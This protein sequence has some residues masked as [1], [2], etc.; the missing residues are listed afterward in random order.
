MV[1]SSWLPAASTQDSLLE[2]TQKLE[3]FTRD[4]WR[5]EE[6]L[7]Q[8]SVNAI[9]KTSDGYM[10]LATY[11]GLARFDGQQ[12][13]I[14]DARNTKGLGSSRIYTLFA[15]HAGAL[16]VFPES[17]RREPGSGIT[18]KDG[19]FTA[20]PFVYGKNIH[21]AADGSLWS[22]GTS[23]LT[24]FHEGHITTYTQR[25]GL[26]SLSIRDVQSSS[27]GSVWIATDEGLAR[28]S[29]ERFRTYT[30]KDGLPS[31]SVG[32]ICAD[33]AGNLW[34]AS[35][36]SLVQFHAGRFNTFTN[37]D[38]T[39]AGRI[40]QIFA[41]VHGDIW[42]TA[43]RSL[44]R[45]SGDQ[46]VS[47]SIPDTPS[48]LVEDAKNGNLWVQ[49][50]DSNLDL[51]KEGRIVPYITGTPLSG[52]PIHSLFADQ[53]GSLWIGR[54][55]GGLERLKPALI[56]TYTKSDGLLENEILTVMESQEGSIWIGTNGGGVSRLSNGEV[57]TYTIEN[58]L[59]SNDVWSLAEDR[60]GALWIGTGQG[61]S[62]LESN[63]ISE[64]LLTGEWILSILQDGQGSLWVGTNHGLH[65]LAGGES[66]HYTTQN[67]L[68]NN[69]VR[70]IHEDRKNTLWLATD[71]GISRVQNGTFINYTT[72]DGLSDLFVRSIHEDS[73]GTLWFGTYGNGFNRFKDGRFTRY[74]THDGLFDHTASQILEDGLGNFWMTGNKGIYRLR[75]KDLN[76]F[77]DG[78]LR[79][80]AP[81]L[82]GTEEGL[83][84]VECNGG[85]QPA[86]WQ[87]RDGRLWFPTMG[88]VA[89]IDPKQLGKNLMPPGV[90]IEETTINGKAV[91][92]TET[93]I[94]PGAGNL[95]F[96]YAGL[97]YLAPKM[98]RY[99]YQ[100]KGF[101]QNW[102]DA[103][104]RRVAY[105]TNVPPG[106]YQFTVVAANNDG[107]WSPAGASFSFYL[108]PHFY[109]TYWF[110]GLCILLTLAVPLTFYVARVRTLKFREQQL[111]QR[112]AQRTAQ[113]QQSEQQF[114]QLFD[115]APLG[116]AMLDEQDRIVAV[117]KAFESIFQFTSDEI[118][119]RHI[120]E[121]IVPASR[122]AEAMSMSRQTADGIA[123]PR[124]TLRQ[125]KDGSLVPVELYGVPVRNQG[126]LEGMYGMYVDISERKRAEE[127]LKKAKEA[128][129]S[130]NRA[131]SA[132]LAVM[133][134]E[135]RTPMNGIIGMTDL[136]LD[137]Q[138]NREQRES[139]SLVKVS[140]EALLSVINDTLDFS[141]IEA[142]KLELESIDFDLQECLREA[143]KLLGLRAH[144]KGLELIC[145]IQSDVPQLL[146]GD[147]GRFRQILINL[148][149]NA[150]KFTAHGYVMVTIEQQSQREGVI[151][152]HVKVE[153]TGIGIPPDKQADIFQAFTQGDG[154]ITRKFGGT[155]LGLAIS[156]RL[157]EAMGGRIWVESELGRGS[158]FH[159]TITF[160]PQKAANRVVPL[161]SGRFHGLRVLLVE[162]HPI[163][164]RVL[165]G[166]LQANQME[167]T[168]V[169]SAAEALTALRQAGESG[170][171]FG[172]ILLNAHMPVMDGFE[173]A[174]H[175]K[176][177]QALL[178][179]TIM[180]LT[181]VGY[182]NDAARCRDAGI[183]IHLVKPILES[184]LLQAIR[185]AL[186]DPLN[187][188]QTSD[189]VPQRTPS[190]IRRPLRILLAE[191]N[192]FNQKLAQRVLQR[193]GH[194]VVLVGNGQE[195]V[196]AA[197]DTDF[198]LILMDL[199]MP[200]MDGLEATAEIRRKEAAIGRHVPII[201]MTAHVLKGDRERCLQCG[202]DDYLAKPLK[203][204]E[205]INIIS[206]YSSKRTSR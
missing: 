177:D 54:A 120:N 53:E 26:P 125:R 127:E 2:K 82:Y 3:H 112:V 146:L 119:L 147:P 109:E 169:A 92:P 69:F 72:K 152:L 135:I 98:V 43:D 44:I 35:G 87:A 162:N 5:I 63:K 15:D 81:S 186:C 155:G 137:T 143:M 100:L 166:L 42:L 96:H 204:S 30:T 145:D 194:E 84:D 101:D 151:T 46:F 150:I 178:G 149:G 172:L 195:A 113:L 198:D 74:T 192:A 66:V 142:G 116:I 161:P 45:L 111:T 103:E 156:S 138:L 165:A 58:G 47:L 173:L 52:K 38:L 1:L 203:H 71:G 107:V 9:A 181:S 93:R 95:E 78:K 91:P 134:H 182:F 140:A 124:E 39:R 197:Q 27:D 106:N 205:V 200:I 185:L 180:M 24:R 6:G 206:T 139:L 154:S 176:Q 174:Q 28:F 189:P 133:S 67:G 73:D 59:P 104:T 90:V 117:N 132:F 115:N 183:R 25:S 37:N 148:V 141:K 157:V 188:S 36:N 18:Y 102:I 167:P 86:G 168:S 121:M 122:T 48:N 105:Y 50:G 88:G 17:D 61:L 16:W 83:K 129:E 10:W 193:E 32:P 163:N 118:S 40:R 20:Q 12:F 128:A 49:V 89:V 184:E 19:T 187:D 153:D 126:R 60:N 79:L 8:S 34:I 179:A 62:R 75:K 144:E 136:V 160:V 80:L 159:F 85:S 94:P 196:M 175:L 77:A 123:P 29:N 55:G 7:P 56:T 190:G 14:F 76:D 158:T 33:R 191:D 164:R 11:D 31:N 51:I 68:P 13:K 57:T 65:R 130:A 131:K 171:T 199:E 64:T 4:V 202:M 41:D 99:K 170:E 97:S 114:R 70:A 110:Y 23:G 108:Q 22:Y 21:E 201:A